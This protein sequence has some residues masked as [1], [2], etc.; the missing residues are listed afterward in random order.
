MRYILHI[1]HAAWAAC[2]PMLG[3]FTEPKDVWRVGTLDDNTQYLWRS[4]EGGDP[5]QPEVQL[6]HKSFQVC[7]CACV[8]AICM[9]A[10]TCLEGACTSGARHRLRRPKRVP[11]RSCTSVVKGL[12]KRVQASALLKDS[13]HA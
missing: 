7:M 1:E 5:S 9:L 12:P 3:R 10:L 11:L 8:G 2:L 6:W 4:V 13:L